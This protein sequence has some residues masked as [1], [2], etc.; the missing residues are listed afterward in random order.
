MRS[1]FCLPI[2][3]VAAKFWTSS[4]FLMLLSEV[5]LKET[6][7]PND[8]M[9]PNTPEMSQMVFSVLQ[10]PV[11]LIW[12]CPKNYLY[13]RMSQRNLG[14]P[15]SFRWLFGLI[16]KCQLPLWVRSKA[17]GHEVALLS[18]QNH[19]GRFVFIPN[20]LGDFYLTIIAISCIKM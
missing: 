20:V 3:I 6:G 9:F 1:N 13:V 12:S 5:R 8:R 10:K 11:W 18:L 16:Q 7:A 19:R 14:R 17:R 4:I 15:E 2:I